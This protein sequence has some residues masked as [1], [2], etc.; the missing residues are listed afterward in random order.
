MGE[1][2]AATPHRCSAD[3]S[4]YRQSV[5]EGRGMKYNTTPNHDTGC[6][7]NVAIYNAIVQQLFTTIFPDSNPTIEMLK[8]EAGFVSKQ[9]VVQFRYPWSQ[10]IA[11]LTAQKPVVSSQGQTKQWT[12]YGLPSLLQT[13]SNGTSGH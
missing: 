5:L 12:L 8:A 2:Q 3:C 6:R 4:V 13:A 7:T 10:F 11:L 1:P 9:N